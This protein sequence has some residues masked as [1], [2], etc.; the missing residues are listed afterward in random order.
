MT[1]P[2]TRSRERSC[3][4]CEAA[5]WRR[6][7]RSRS[8]STTAVSMQR[9]SSSCLPPLCRADRRRRVH[10]GALACDRGGPCLDRRPRRSRWRRIR[11][12][13]PQDR[14]GSG[15]P[16]LEGF[17]RRDLPRRRPARRRPDRARGSPGLRLLCQTLAARRAER[18]GRTRSRASDVCRRRTAGGAL[19]RE[20]LVPGARQLCARARRQQGSH[21]AC[22]VPMPVRC[23][24][25]ASPRRDRAIKVAQVLMEPQFFSG[26][27]MRTIA[28]SEVRY[29]PMSYHNGSIWP[30]DNALIALGLARY[31]L[32]R[33]VQR[34]FKGLFEAATYLELRRLP[35][36]FCGFQRGRGRGPT[37]YP[38]ACA[39]QAWASATPFTLI[40]ASLGLQ[41]DTRP[42]T[43][44]ACTTHGCPTS[45]I[46]SCYA[47]CGSSRRASTSRCAAMATRSRW[48]FWSGE[49]PVQVAVVFG[50][51][52]DPD[53][54]DPGSLTPHSAILRRDTNSSATM[55]ADS[56][57]TATRI[58]RRG[59]SAAPQGMSRRD[60]CVL[61]A[62]I[63]GI[64]AALEAARLGRKVVLVDGLPA[65]GGQAVNSIIGT[66]C[67]LFANG[68]HGY[69]LTHGIAD[70]ILR[71]LGAQGRSI[72]AAAAPPTRPSSCMT[73]SRSHAGSR[74]PFARAGITVLLGAILRGVTRDRRRVRELELA[75]RYGD[76][77]LSAFGF[78]D[79][80]G[81]AALTW[82]AGF[83]CREHAGGPDLRY[84]DDGARRDRRGAAAAPRRADRA[85][86]RQ[87]RGLRLRAHRWICLRL[88]RARHCAGQFHP[89]RDPARPGRSLENALDGKAQAD[90][91]LD[92]LQREYPLA[93]GNARVRSYGLPGI[94]QT[95]WIAGRQQLTRRGCARRH[96]V[97]RRDR[98][99]LLADR[100][101]R[102]PAKAMSG[103]PSRTTTSTTSRSPAWF[104]A[105]PTTSW[106]PAAASTATAPRF[107]ACGSWAPAS[108]WARPP[109]MR[110]SLPAAAAYSRSTLCG[111]C[112]NARAGLSAEPRS[113]RR[114]GDAGGMT[115]MHFGERTPPG[116][117]AN[118]HPNTVAN[119][120]DDGS[121]HDIRAATFRFIGKPVVRKEDERL[122]TGRG[123]FSDDFSLDRPGP[124]GHGTLPARR[125]PASWRNRRGTGEGKRRACSACSPAPTAGT[126]GWPPSRMTR[127]PRPN[128]T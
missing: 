66:F 58:V 12:V 36:L 4:R 109:P 76:L 74:K 92:F 9:R 65:L 116:M 23:C 50:R 69:Q 94:R 93:F 56:I 48:R 47:T 61:G 75:T 114:G 3:T 32:K 44:S 95:R 41:F 21:A 64:S 24:S 49:E 108:P 45:W 110:S 88:S 43:K 83:A 125:M 55:D 120:V 59:R 67:G 26:W 79:A 122:T 89:C 100:A 37:L 71:D 30:H 5:R 117:P 119:C 25:P 96:Q 17:A 115:H 33:S 98:A 8:A 118:S 123:R 99:H 13:L 128:M 102:S 39:P 46:E 104:R 111:A 86:A 31:R 57:S 62:G 112:D 54:A 29:N 6:C 107:R 70:D 51:T 113:L 78:V 85:G 101:A 22:A 82:Q 81:D 1:R 106:L 97:S 16:G 77:T 20:F 60:I 27:G 73:R 10:F 34:V 18:Q 40:E 35:E 11:R 14:A 19:R 126:T 15:Q 87:G 103:N 28:N 84:P 80:T 105:R 2:R 53:E 127:C 7:A 52:A 38:V 63:A 42:R 90:R 91:V 124:C 68:P 72:T 121:Q